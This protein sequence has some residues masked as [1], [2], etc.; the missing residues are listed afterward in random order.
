MRP[1]KVRYATGAELLEHVAQSQASDN[2]G[3]FFPTREA[4]P[5]GEQVLVE[6]RFP[7]LANPMVFRGTVGW[8]RAGK[9]RAKLR[10]GVGIGFQAAEGRRWDFLIAVAKGDIVEMI[11]R[12]HRRIP[13]H[14]TANWRVACDREVH[15]TVLEDIGPGGAFLRTTELLPPG[16]EVV[17]DVQPPGSVRPLEIMGRVVWARHSD[18]MEGLGVE[19]K[20][21]DSG[22]TR[23]L[24]ELVRRLEILEAEDAYDP[25]VEAS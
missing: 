2:R 13:V 1:L 24:K 19:F 23:R 8:R 4:L 9:H 15:K 11:T 12:R 22:G 18:G 6:I 17:L 7:G 10:A 25:N 16:T 3:I 20:S 14:L 21:R 5:I